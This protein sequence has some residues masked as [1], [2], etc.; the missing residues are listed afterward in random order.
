MPLILAFHRHRPEPCVG[1]AGP[2]YFKGYIGQANPDVGNIFA[3]EFEFNNTFVVH[4]KDIKST[5][6]YGIGFGY[7]TGHWFRFDITGE[8]RGSAVFLAEDSYQQ[9]GPATNEYTVDIESWVGLFN[10]YIDLG[11]W[12]CVTPFVGGGVGFAS[13]DVI[14]LKDVNV[15]VPGGAV[16]FAKDHTETSRLGALCRSRLRRDAGRHHRSLLSLSRSRRRQERYPH[17]L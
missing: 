13:I 7:D 3:P 12:H 10:T 14:G 6:L 16:A 9:F 8:Y 5:P 1:C 15:T 11:T 2:W 4:H 17:G